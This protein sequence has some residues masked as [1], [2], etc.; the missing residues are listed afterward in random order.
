MERATYRA[1]IDH[2]QLKAKRSRQHSDALRK[3]LARLHPATG[4]H[5]GLV[6]NWGN[7]AARAAVREADKRWQRF[8]A[9]HDKR[10]RELARDDLRASG[11]NPA[12]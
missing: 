12:F 2:C 7:D 10:Y 4:G 3:R 5:L 1:L 8:S 9:W 6:H 11:L